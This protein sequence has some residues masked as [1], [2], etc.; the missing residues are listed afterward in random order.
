[1]KDRRAVANWLLLEG[2][3]VVRWLT[4]SQ[5]VDRPQERQL[6]KAQADLLAAPNVQLWLNRLE[7]VRGFHN[8]DN[9][10]FENVAGKLGEFGLRAGMGPL[11]KRMARFQEWLAHRDRRGERGMMATLNR[12]IA[13][14]GLMRLGYTKPEAVREFAFSRLD[15]LARIAS[16]G[17]YD[18]FCPEDPPDLP[19]AY[20]G[21]HRVVA[22]EFTPDGAC[23]LPYVHDLYLFANL[24]KAWLTDAVRRK[25][26]VIVR[27]ILA[28]EYQRLPNGY[29]YLCDDAAKNPRYY[30][31]GWGVDLPGHGRMPPSGRKQAYFIQRLELM[32]AFAP[33]RKHPWWWAAMELLDTHRTSEGRYSFPAQWLPEKP[34]GYWVTGSHMG[35]E[36]NR[37]SGLARELESTFRYLRLRGKQ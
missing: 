12:T 5:L 21:R 2:G 35:L 17:R 14:A 6:R 11:D 27:Y 20:R 30:V 10:C 32:S 1:M 19:K 4:L 36:E 13:C 18:I 26:G 16:W 24:P 29:G 28:D 8:S 23:W 22:Q 33:A 3:P 25:I 37:R 7:G 9:A 31:L 15:Q 34:V